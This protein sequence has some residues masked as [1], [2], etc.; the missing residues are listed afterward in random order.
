ML[1]CEI[2]CEWTLKYEI[3]QALS[4]V[5]NLFAFPA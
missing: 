1:N 3:W 5:Y 2:F 4:S